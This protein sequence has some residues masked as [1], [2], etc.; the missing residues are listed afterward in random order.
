MAKTQRLVGDGLLGRLMTRAGGH[1]MDGVP[2]TTFTLR[3]GQCRTS[4]RQ[5]RRCCG[6]RA[7]R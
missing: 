5:G 2:S 7:L 6:R 4:L 3:H 1:S